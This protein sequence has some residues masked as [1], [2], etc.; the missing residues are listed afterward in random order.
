MAK[1]SQK[2]LKPP[3]LK[4]LWFTVADSR[5]PGWGESSSYCYCPQTE[6]VKVMF[7]HVSVCPLVGGYLGR[8]PPPGQVHPRAGTPQQIHAPAGT[9]PCRYIPQ[10]GTLPPGRYNPHREQCVLGDTNNKW[11][12]RILLECV[13]VRSNFVK[14]ARE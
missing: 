9:P 14:N 12:V 3:R 8:Y 13:L 11:V 4:I 5:F 2:S 6:F 10:A 7:L 1:N